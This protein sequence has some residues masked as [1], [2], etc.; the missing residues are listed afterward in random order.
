L[1]GTRQNLVERRRWPAGKVDGWINS[2]LAAYV[3][4]LVEGLSRKEEMSLMKIGALAEALAQNSTEGVKKVTLGELL[5][6]LKGGRALLSR[7]PRRQRGSRV[8]R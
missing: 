1:T 4:G 8:D 3:A 6:A 2:A 7:R 5:A